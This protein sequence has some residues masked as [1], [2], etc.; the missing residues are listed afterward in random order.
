METIKKLLNQLVFYPQGITFDI[1]EVKNPYSDVDGI[2]KDWFKVVI[3]VDS[4]RYHKYSD[5]YDEHYYNAFAYIDDRLYS[6]L[7]YLQKSNNLRNVV[8]NHVNTDF[9]FN[10][11]KNKLDNKMEEHLLRASKDTGEEYK[12]E[13]EIFFDSYQPYPTILLTNNMPKEYGDSLWWDVSDTYH[14]DDFYVATNDYDE[15]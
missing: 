5:K 12:G 4:E 8:Y 3:D 13:V 10:D 6:A 14:L 9:I 7:N 15:D 1:D 2:S 11:L